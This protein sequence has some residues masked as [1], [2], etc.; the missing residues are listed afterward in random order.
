MAVRPHHAGHGSVLWGTPSGGHEARGFPRVSF[1]I[2]NLTGCEAALLRSEQSASARS[3]GVRGQLRSVS[4]PAG[5]CVDSDRPRGSAAPGWVA[6]CSSHGAPPWRRRI[7]SYSLQKLLA[8]YLVPST[9]R[10]RRRRT[11]RR[12]ARARSRCA[13][14]VATRATVSRNR[15]TSEGSTRSFRSEEHTSELQSRLHLVCRLL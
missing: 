9:D 6:E 2:L 14:A 10:S 11:P 1:T 7:R 12:S 13:M 4:S 3:R 8:I 15:R 5:P